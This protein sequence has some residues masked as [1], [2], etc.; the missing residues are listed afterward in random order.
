MDKDV[1]YSSY[2]HK[3]SN[4]ILYLFTGIRYFQLKTRKIPYFDNASTIWTSKQIS[5]NSN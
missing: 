4:F 3:I 1:T 5:A 2:K